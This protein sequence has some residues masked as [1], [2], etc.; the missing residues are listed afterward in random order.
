[1]KT[2]VLAVRLLCLCAFIGALAA[3]EEEKTDDTV[4]PTP[5]PL[6]VEEIIV[7]P[8]ATSPEDTVA[9]TAD[10][11][12]S[13]QNVGDVPATNWTADGGTFIENNKLTVHWIAPTTPGFYTISVRAT[14]DAGSASAQTTLYVGSQTLLVS[15]QAGSVH[16]LANGTDFYYRRSPDVSRGSEVYSYIGG[17]STDAVNP[18][19]PTGLDITLDPAVTYEVH[20]GEVTPRDSV[21]GVVNVSPTLFHIYKGDFTLRTLQRIT[22]DLA[23]TGAQRR[24]QFRYPSVSPDGQMITYQGLVTNTFSASLDS[25]DVFVYTI[26]G[27][28]RIRATFTHSNHR[29]FV[30]TFSTD[31]AWLTFLSDRSGA[32]QWEIYGMP[33]SGL[34]VDTDPAS[35]VRLTSTGGTIASSQSGGVP[36]I[37]LRAWNP[38]AP[39]LAVVSSEGILYLMTTNG[40]G[41]TVTEVDGLPTSILELKWSSDGSELAVAASATVDGRAVAQLYTV[42]GGSAELRYQSIPGDLARDMVWS[43]DAQWLV[44][45]V[46]RS[47]GAW[48]EIL[49][50]AGGTLDQPVPLSGAFLAGEAGAYRSVMS[51]SPAWGAGDQLIAPVW[52]GEATPGIIALDVSS[53]VQ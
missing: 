40:G 51:L 48:F 41:A 34:T 38:V 29:N 11:R 26:P 53:A 35:V 23:E 36:S 42:S 28:T 49:D 8:K 12:S 17:I 52:R 46:T 4:K 44:Y 50:L 24:N 10:I 7:S 45:R 13:S 39:T 20:S 21:G 31:Q 22:Q 33:V 19:R 9:L 15:N 43:P 47:T 14:N 18:V 5:T 32:N 25:V 16:L 27:P 2:T 6:R 30:P 1:M 3:C 37:P